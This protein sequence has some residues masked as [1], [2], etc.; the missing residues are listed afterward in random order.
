[1]RRAWPL[2]YCL[3]GGAAFAQTGV[4]WQY[5]AP[6]E[7]PSEREFREQVS[8]NLLRDPRTSELA[9]KLNAGEVRVE[10]RLEPSE[11]RASLR[12]QEPG[13]RVVERTIEGDSCGELAS[14]LAL[15]TALAFG[16]PQ[17]PSATTAGE[18]PAKPTETP[19]PAVIQPSAKPPA[20]SRPPEPSPASDRAP[21][22][23]HLNVEVGAGG[24]LDT[25]SAPDLTY[26]VDA[27]IRLAPKA[28]TTWSLRLAGL[29][30]ASTATVDSRRAD[31]DYLGGRA[32]GCPISQRLPLRLTAEAC[33]ALDLGALRGTGDANSALAEATSHT[34]FWAAAM[35]SARLRARIA[36][37]VSLEGQAELGLPFVRHEFVFEDPRQRIFQV[38]AAGFG[39]RLGLGVEFL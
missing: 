20:D 12:F 35:I 8:A 29:Y 34:I 7:C 27:F 28:R 3:L 2:A 13:L 25:W 5:S 17:E 32:E 15:I 9:S 37:P 39:A 30:G 36:G 11:H 22:S 33:V 16:D 31:F 14:G 38:P 18:A 10:V 4:S 21:A 24:W 23:P 19:P 26:G 1:M 6:A